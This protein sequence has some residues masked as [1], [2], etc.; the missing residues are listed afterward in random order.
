MPFWLAGIYLHGAPLALGVARRVD[1]A[2]LAP[3]W[4]PL[5]PR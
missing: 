5:S 1:A 4:L 2:G 3:R